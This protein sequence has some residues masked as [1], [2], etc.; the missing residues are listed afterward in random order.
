MPVDNSAI[1]TF[2]A[3]STVSN[4]FA[5]RAHLIGAAQLAQQYP[6]LTKLTIPA[7]FTSTT[8]GL[9]ASDDNSTWTTLGDFRGAISQASV[10]AN[11]VI[12]LPVE[13]TKDWRY[14]RLTSSATQAAQ[15]DIVAEVTFTNVPPAR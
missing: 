1:I 8:L 14:V 11:A 4:V 12:R 13:L 3:S 7:A 10:A 9:D 2:P 5:L 6:A 15:R